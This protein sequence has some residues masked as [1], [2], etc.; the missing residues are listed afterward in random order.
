MLADVR[1]SSCFK[2]SKSPPF[3]PAGTPPASQRITEVLPSTSTNVFLK[4]FVSVDRPGH[5][6]VAGKV[7]PARS[8]PRDRR[9]RRGRAKIAHLS[10][11]RAGS[12]LV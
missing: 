6:Q 1:E 10:A 7:F 2:P 8:A 3:E 11:W 4:S 5:V 12:L 9:G